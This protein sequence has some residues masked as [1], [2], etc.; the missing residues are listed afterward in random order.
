ME[1]SEARAVGSTCLCLRVR[2]AARRVGR[3]FD[4]AL[5]P[6]GL[7]NGQFSLL[8]MLAARDDWT[9]QGLADA[10][11]ADQSSL[12][13]ALK[14]LER[15]GLVRTAAGAD[16]RRVRRPALTP[17]GAALLDEALPLWRSAQDRAEAMVGGPGAERLRRDLS[18]LT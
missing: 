12:T 10:L 9:M 4:E 14:P 18:R 6:V 11:G 16:D 2:K 15:R 13:A 5:S 1:P 7:T 17:A 8:A 3:M